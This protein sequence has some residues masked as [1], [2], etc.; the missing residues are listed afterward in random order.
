MR[1]RHVA[2]PCNHCLSDAES[3]LRPQ[4]T[5]RNRFRHV[6]SQRLALRG[7]SRPRTRQT[8]NSRREVRV[9]L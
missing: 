2:V 4:P 8:I 1:I 9:N 5:E 3:V 7:R 6:C